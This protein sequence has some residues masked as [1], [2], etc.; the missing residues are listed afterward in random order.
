MKKQRRLFRK[1]GR[2]G[3][4]LVVKAPNLTVTS[5]RHAEERYPT[6]FIALSR[7][8]VN[9]NGPKKIVLSMARFRLSGHN[10]R[11]ETGR[12]EGLPRNERS[13]CRCKIV[14]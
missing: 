14:R 1:H 4:Q 10:L 12:H 7:L 11:I 6:V 3:P 9:K 8:Q 5:A 2:K 13:C